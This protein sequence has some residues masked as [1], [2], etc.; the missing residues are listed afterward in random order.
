MF[1]LFSSSKEPKGL[2]VY[3]IP[4]ENRL[5]V[6]ENLIFLAYY[7]GDE[8]SRERPIPGKGLFV[9]VIQSEQELFSLIE[10]LCKTIG[11]YDPL[12]R[13]DIFD[14]IENKWIHHFPFSQD[15]CATPDSCPTIFVRLNDMG[16]LGYLVN[17]II[18]QLCEIRLQK[19][20]LEGDYSLCINLM[21]V[22]FGLAGIYLVKFSGFRS[23][24][25]LRSDC[26]LYAAALMDHFTGNQEKTYLDA[27][28]AQEQIDIK[29]L[30]RSIITYEPLLDLQKKWDAA[31]RSYQIQSEYP[32]EGLTPEQEIE[33]SSRLL[34]VQ[35]DKSHIYN[36]RGYF[37]LYLGQY[38]EAIKDFDECIAQENYYDYA[39]NNRGFAKLLLGQFE[40]GKEDIET[41]IRLNPENGMAWRNLGFFELKEGDM[42]KGLEYILKAQK[43]LPN[44]DLIHFSLAFAYR[45]NGQQDMVEKFE[46]LSKEKDERRYPSNA[47]F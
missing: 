27:L 25:K 5:F 29:N 33:V 22:Y 3:D 20:K 38:I 15:P 35:I 16:T 37:M 7:F 23:P 42:Q 39:F 31:V 36:H 26:Y 43:I 46:T 45:I 12:L 14:G 24:F 1:R 30:Y 10:K 41:A 11:A 13:V 6:E 8:F 40:D 18:V 2:T 4:E 34:E 47:L 21:P 17:E 28:T 44:M 9:N 32:F 19:Y